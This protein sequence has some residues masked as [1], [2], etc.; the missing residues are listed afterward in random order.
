MSWTVW[1]RVARL[2]PRSNNIPCAKE[3]YVAKLVASTSGDEIVRSWPDYHPPSLSITQNIHTVATIT[4]TP[5][6][7]Y[8][9]I[10]ILPPAPV[11][12]VVEACA[13]EAS[14]EPVDSAPVVDAE[15]DVTLVSALCAMLEDKSDVPVASK[16]IVS[17]EEISTPV[18][19]VELDVD[20]DTKVTVAESVLTSIIGVDI[21]ETESM[22]TTT[23]D[24]DIASPD[25]MLPTAVK[26]AS[27]GTS[28]TG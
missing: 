1:R 19:C 4:P 26:L 7:L 8:Q 21:A 22:L 17:K 9:L 2:Q 6:T 3:V 13:S 16:I 27:A 11:V 24:V 20:V 10:P 23:T 12:V 25:P 28:Q 5:T 15:D 14:V 18:T